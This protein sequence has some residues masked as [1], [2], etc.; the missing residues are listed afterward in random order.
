MLPKL[1]GTFICLTFDKGTVRTTLNEEEE[2]LQ[3]AV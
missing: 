3:P 1:C 2:S